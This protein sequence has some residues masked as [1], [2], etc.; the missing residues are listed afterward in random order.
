MVTS[1]KL[2]TY[3]GIAT[4]A[5][6]REFAAQLGSVMYAMT[7]TRP[8][9]AF[10]VSALAQHTRNP[11]PEHWVALKRIFL[12]L[13]STMDYSITFGGEV[14]DKF[15]LAGYTDASFAEDC[16]TRRSTGAYIFTLNGGP[17]SWTSKRQSTVALSTTEA[18]YM[19]MCQAIK[20]ATWLRQLLTELSVHQGSE[21]TKVHADNK[22]AI[23]LGKNPEFHKRS[24]HIDVQYHYVRQEVQSGRIT[25]PFLPTA[26]M[27]ADGLTKALSPEL[28]SRF[29]DHCNLNQGKRLASLRGS[30]GR[31]ILPP[32]DASK[33]RV[34]E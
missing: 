23:A 27:V 1:Q 18:E 4:Q 21:P 14:D 7:T 9:I 33:Q 8:D 5:S 34:K 10:A 13:R 19:A 3:D 2:D 6:I 12:Y 26:E 30:V 11:G 28:H 32:G 22:G 16:A 25:T 17:V 29:I 24:K 20:E 31:A 15:E